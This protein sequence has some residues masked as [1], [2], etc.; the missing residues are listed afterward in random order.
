MAKKKR[1]NAVT[2]EVGLYS[3]FPFENERNKELKNVV[4]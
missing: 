4:F 3:F 2:S 1:I